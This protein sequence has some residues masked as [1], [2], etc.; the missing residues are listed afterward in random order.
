MTY[1]LRPRL[2]THSSGRGVSLPFVVNLNGFGVVMFRK[3]GKY[4]AV[5]RQTSTRKFW[6][7]PASADDTILICSLN[8][9]EHLRLRN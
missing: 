3:M 7:E 9:L 4:Y 8:S 1:F 2:T 5:C 6:Q